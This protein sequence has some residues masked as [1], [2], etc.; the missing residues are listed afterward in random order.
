MSLLSF[1]YDNTQGIS[2]ANTLIQIM[3]IQVCVKKKEKKK[4]SLRLH[5]VYNTTPTLYTKGLQ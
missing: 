1:I 3:K 5:C 2:S 4:S